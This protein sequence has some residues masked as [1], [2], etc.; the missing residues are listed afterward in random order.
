VEKNY[1]K[2]RLFL[3]TLLNLAAQGETESVQYIEENIQKGIASVL[4]K[5]YHKVFEENSVDIAE[6]QNA[7][8]YYRQLKGCMDQPDRKY[9]LN[10]NDG[11]LLLVAL[12]LNEIF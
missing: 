4:Y 3:T 6:I 7:D 8:E 9:N 11:I 2:L 10:D 12:A 1:P 5:K